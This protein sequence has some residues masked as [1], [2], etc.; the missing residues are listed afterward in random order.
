MTQPRMVGGRYELGELIGYGGMA[1]VHRGRDTRLNRDVAIKV[2]RADLARDQTFLNR[3]RR[4]AHSAAGLNHPSIVSVYDTGEDVAPDGTAVPFIVMEYVEGRTLRDILRSEGPLPPRRAMEITADICSALD[5]SHRNGIIHRDIKPANV[6]ITQSGA[7]KVMD[8]GI[9][10]AVADT[11]ATVTQ[12]A[13][14]IGTAQYLSPEQARGDAVDARSDV[15]STGCLLYE[16]VTGVPPFQGDSPVAVAYQHVRENPVMPSSRNPEVPRSLDS[17]VMK[18]L[19]KNQ[20][21][22]YQSA[23]DMRADL[24]RAIADQPVTAEAVMTDAERTQFISRTPP[25]P[26]PPRHEV[27]DDVEDDHRR[28]NAL[29]WVAVVVA[30]LLVIG[31]GSF[32]LFGTSHN[33]GP[34]MVRVAAV[35]GELPSAAEQQL[36]AQKLVPQLAGSTTGPCTDGQTVA[37]GHVCTTTPT[38]NKSIAQGTT[39]LYRVYKEKSVTVTSYTNQQYSVAAAALH[40]LGL[41]PKQKNVYNADK[42]GT[43]E[44][45]SVAPYKVVL[46]GSTVTLSVSTG[47]LKLPDVRGKNI[48]DAKSDLPTSFHPVIRHIVTHDSSKDQ[49]VATESP[50]AGEA[51]APGQRVTLGVYEYE[52]PQPTCTTPPATPPD[53]GAPSTDSSTSASSTSTIPACPTTTPTTPTSGG[54]PTP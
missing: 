12:T 37:V 8:F 13:N 42:K 51:Y 39:V 53:T 30:L 3:F 49:I 43:V 40:N 48:A 26:V 46:A 47:T 36:K 33:N 25:P 35:T 15:Y 19:A 22:R 54:T 41:V 32:V 5:F 18:A 50:K 6:M 23:G 17:V 34:K 20:L 21:N 10:R 11:S 27:Y 1:E 4:E 29:I 2:L 45:Q 44:G 31:I 14:V 9:A 28:R 38:A 52:Q 7:V 16:L 24:Q